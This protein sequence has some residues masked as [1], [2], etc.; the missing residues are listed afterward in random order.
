MLHD[1]KELFEQVI[2]KTS[3]HFRIEVGIVEKDYFVTLF[4]REIVKNQPN[5]IFKGGTSLSKCYK[6]IKRFSEDIDL[7]LE[8]DRH[9]TQG[10]RKVLKENILSSI[11]SLGFSLSNPNDIHS[12]R[13]YNRY[14]VD[15]PTTFSSSYLK[16]RLIAETAVYFR[17]Y[18]T[19]L[20]QAS[21]I[22]YDFLSENGYGDIVDAYDLHPFS[23]NVQL[24]DRTLIDKLFALGD[25]YLAGAVSE[26]SRHLYDLYKLLDLVKIDAK[27]AELYRSVREE[28]KPYPSCRSAKEGV[29]LHKILCE[30]IENDVYKKDFEDITSG[31]LYENVDYSTVKQALH[32]I[33]DSVLFY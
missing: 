2:L 1:D 16:P 9:P 13:D 33:A 26:H 31:L 15:Y 21:S 10:E 30:I 24:A 4:L 7:T 19:K 28:R 22:V 5:I 18:P 6:I 25:Y 20:M 14:L 12:R 23:V 11:N 32:S 29:D 8:C 27:L 17:A 3:E